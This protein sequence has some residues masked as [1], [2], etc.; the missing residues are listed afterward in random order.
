MFT[1][2]RSSAKVSSVVRDCSKRHRLHTVLTHVESAMSDLDR[3]VLTSNGITICF[4][5]LSFQGRFRLVI[6][7][8]KKKNMIVRAQER[9]RV[10]LS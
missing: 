9:G 5:I 10:G 3:F 6:N 2:W 4:L 8:K 1:R 7:K